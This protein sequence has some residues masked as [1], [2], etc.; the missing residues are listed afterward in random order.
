MA[1]RQ[2]RYSAGRHVVAQFPAVEHK[3]AVKPGDDSHNSRV[4][5]AIA[6]DAAVDVLMA[7]G[8]R[9][10]PA[11]NS[12]GFFNIATRAGILN[13]PSV[14]APRGA[15]SLP[16][17][18]SFGDILRTVGDRYGVDERQRLAKPE[19]CNEAGVHVRMSRLPNL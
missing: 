15:I 7:S 1:L 10:A 8:G 6:A 3:Y 16:V 11:E 4:F 12:Y 5:E 9:C 13:L 14:N 19:P 17:S 18:P 2:W